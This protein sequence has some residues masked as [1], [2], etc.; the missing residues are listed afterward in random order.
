MIEAHIVGLN[1]SVNVK[2]PLKPLQMKEIAVEI[3]ST[4]FHLS[5]AEIFYVFRKAKKGGYG[6]FYNALSMPVVLDWFEQ[7]SEERI[8]HFMEGQM[9]I[10]DK[11][12]D[13]SLRSDER[14]E[15]RRHNEIINDHKNKNDGK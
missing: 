9:R 15:L 11:H 3:Q 2:M 4:F 8:K 5:M 12:K 6:I 13:D 7:Y 10:H 14:K 1:E